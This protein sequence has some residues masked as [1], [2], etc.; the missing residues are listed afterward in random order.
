MAIK[1]V[2]F[3][4]IYIISVASEVKV[5]FVKAIFTKDGLAF[6]RLSSFRV[7][8]SVGSTQVV[9]HSRSSV[10]TIK[11]MICMQHFSSTAEK[12][13]VVRSL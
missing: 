13:M 10:F 7:C 1:L 8:A 3:I 2:V 11:P 4:H 5:T 6:V 12:G 9:W